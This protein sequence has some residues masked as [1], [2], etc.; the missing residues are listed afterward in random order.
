MDEKQ[1]I[2]E[3]NQQESGQERDKEARP[4]RR[5]K[6]SRE[7]QWLNAGKIES[8]QQYKIKHYIWKHGGKN[9]VRD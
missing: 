9:Y 6:R 3:L 7:I 2:V 1:K 8:I 5:E 4:K